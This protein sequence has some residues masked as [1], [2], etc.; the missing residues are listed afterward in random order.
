MKQVMK[1]LMKSRRRG[2]TARRVS[3]LG[4][5]CS[6]TANPGRVRRE[7]ASR[8]P[9]R[10]AVGAGAFA[11]TRAVSAGAFAATRAVS[12]GAFAATRVA[13][14]VTREC[15]ADDL[16]PLVDYLVTGGLMAALLGLAVLM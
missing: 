7:S 13:G 1:T 8:L 12:E 3:V 10:R 16:S 15:D 2:F 9:A 5:R 14:P 11:A 4:I 6:P